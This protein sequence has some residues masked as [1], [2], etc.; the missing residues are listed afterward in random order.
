MIKIKRDWAGRAVEITTDDGKKSKNFC[1]F[2]IDDV[3]IFNTEENIDTLLLPYFIGANN[4]KIKEWEERYID[5][6]NRKKDLSNRATL[7][8]R[9]KYD[10]GEI[11]V[12]H[13]YDYVA[14]DK[15]PKIKEKA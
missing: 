9:M 7:V 3:G 14:H 5:N 15:K 1:I 2:Y 6:E 11:N 8:P 12:R 10:Q 13:P 4:I